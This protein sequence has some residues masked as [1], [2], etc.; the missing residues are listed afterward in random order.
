MYNI[1]LQQMT[2]HQCQT[3]ASENLEYS[4]CQM[5]YLSFLELDNCGHYELL[6]LICEIKYENFS[7]VRLTKIT[8]YEFKMV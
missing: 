1:Q 8:G 3:M 6:L 4:A 5:D 7:C 2:S